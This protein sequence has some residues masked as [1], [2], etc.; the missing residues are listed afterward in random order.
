MRVK[1]TNN[2]STFRLER[3]DNEQK[4]SSHWQ[5]LG[6]SGRG[7]HRNQTEIEQ[8]TLASGRGAEGEPTKLGNCTSEKYK[9]NPSQR[10]LQ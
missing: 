7:T 4:D 5:I 2:K 1:K 3:R 6:S 9:G 10:S 8:N